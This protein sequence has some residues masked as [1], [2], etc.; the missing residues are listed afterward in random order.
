M[1]LFVAVCVIG[2]VAAGAAATKDPACLARGGCC[3]P[4]LPVLHALR[5][6]VLTPSAICCCPHL[7]RREPRFVPAASLAQVSRWCAV[8]L[9][10]LFR[11]AVDFGR[12]ADIALYHLGCFQLRFPDGRS[13]PLAAVVL[14]GL[15]QQRPQLGID[16]LLETFR[17]AGAVLVISAPKC[18]QCSMKRGRNGGKRVDW[19]PLRKH[20]LPPEL[21]VLCPT[22]T[23]AFCMA[24]MW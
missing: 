13:I 9:S 18:K 14:H 2:A 1:S 17:A 8:L 5:W 22:R 15:Q 10:Q 24:A 11:G 3:R 19:V 7:C 4:R 21:A 23:L 20:L 6:V 16:A 12:P